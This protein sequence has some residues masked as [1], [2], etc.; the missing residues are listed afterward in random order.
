VHIHMILKMPFEC[1]S[2]IIRK[3]RAKEL[4]S[5]LAIYYCREEAGALNMP[6]V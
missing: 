3:E 6:D 1:P 5:T 4:L 2:E